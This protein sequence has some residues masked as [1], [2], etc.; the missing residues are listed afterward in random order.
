[1]TITDELK[2]KLLLNMIPEIGP[3]RANRLLRH[4][5]TAKKIFESTI[6]E[7]ATIEDIGKILAKKILDITK[8]IDINKEIEKIKKL[9]INITTIDDDDYP[10]QLK[11]IPD[12]PIV[13]Y[14]LGKFTKNDIF[15][16]AIVGTRKPTSYGQLV[17]EKLTK[18]LVQLNV[19]IISGLARGIDTIAHWTT[20]KSGGRTIAILGNGLNVYYPPENRKLETE[21]IKSGVLVSEFPLNYPP[22]KS[23]FPRRNRLIAGLSL[24]TV[25]IEGD[26]T[27]GAMITARFALDQGKDVFTVPGSIF[28]KYSRGPH[29]LLKQG[30]KL[31]ESAEDIVQEITTLADWILKSNQKKEKVEELPLLNNIEQEILSKLENE[32]DGLHI[33]KLY[34]LLKRNFSELSQTLISLELKGLIKSLPGKIYIKTIIN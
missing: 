2:Y 25:V 4:F 19:T 22:D 14:Y 12:P 29:L 3:V 16:V 24:G 15:S 17:T 9:N 8:Q 1:M 5:G 23:N 18:E 7:I 31:V 10:A 32:P 34:N 30:A 26:L 33:D 20:I 28:S 27:S 13:L 11:N 21:I 6:D